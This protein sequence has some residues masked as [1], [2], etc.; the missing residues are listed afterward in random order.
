MRLPDGKGIKVTLRDRVI[1]VEIGF[2]VRGELVWD[3]R[4]GENRLNRFV[5]LEIA[6]P[7]WQHEHR[8]EEV[9]L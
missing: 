3:D 7:P 1:V 6:A 2:W 4:F 5:R 8:G 9:D